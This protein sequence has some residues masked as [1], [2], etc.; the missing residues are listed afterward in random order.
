M[1]KFEKLEA[2]TPAPTNLLPAGLSGMLP[3]FLAKETAASV[4]FRDTQ[5]NLFLEDVPT[6]PSSASPYSALWPTIMAA[7][8]G[9]G[10]VEQDAPIALGPNIKAAEPKAAPVQL[11]KPIAP[12]TTASDAE[13][14]I[15]I[16]DAGITF[17]NR[18]FFDGQ[19]NN[20]FV[21]LGA[22]SLHKTGT[23]TPPL[24]HAQINAYARRS[25]REN[26]AELKQLFPASVYGEEASRPLSTPDGLAHGT[27]MAELV[28][29]TAPDDTP[30]NG[31]EMPVSVLRD[32]TGG[33]MA[34]VMGVALRAL[35][36]QVIDR[37]GAEGKDAPFRLIVLMAFAF[38][39]GPLDG[40][41]G[42]LTELDV[43]LNDIK[44]KGY[45]VELVL[46]IGNHLQDQLHA[47]LGA[48]DEIGWRILPEDFSTNTV[49]IIHS[50]EPGSLL[51]AAPADEFIPLPD[52]PGLYRIVMGKSAIGA[53]WSRDIGNGRINTRVALAPTGKRIK[54]GPIAPFGM[55]RLQTLQND[56]K[57]WILRDETGFE[58]DPFMPARRSWFED[59]L[60]RPKD[61]FGMPGL[62]D[63]PTKPSGHTP[64]IRR[65]GTGSVLA[66]ST[67]PSVTVVTS[68]EADGSNAFYAGRLPANSR[69]PEGVS[70]DT[71]I[72][73]GKAQ[74]RKPIGP[75]VGRA[76]LG[77]ATADRFRAQGT[78]MAAA[79]HTGERAA[80]K[81]TS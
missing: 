24:T 19:G 63:R 61:S 74:E 75:F 35:I 58:A 45:D 23:R 77:N 3:D 21:S 12:T 52:G 26:R 72:P 57:M 41:A 68:L 36:N 43:V 39:G 48:E 9:G 60:Y 29:S 51:I 10:T 70:H 2:P 78:S 47:Q 7:D 76:V 1:M 80:P 38:T 20:R 8:I 81:K 62:D 14:E 6:D 28:L 25:D 44:A 4:I 53:V 33:Q 71:A 13:T 67:N 11:A 5:G 69:A 73:P 34:A 56:T 15:G 40:S 49:E 18:A 54:S 42:I 16:I 65:I 30:L 55:W 59:P 32:L 66:S 79:L 46:P 22:L 37:R 50:G 64:R 31:L 27:S 17:W